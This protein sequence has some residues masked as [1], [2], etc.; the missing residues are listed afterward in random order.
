ML[1]AKQYTLL[2][3]KLKSEKNTK[4]F[5]CIWKY[6]LN[7]KSMQA[8]S[9]MRTLEELAVTEMLPALYFPSIME[10]SATELLDLD[11]SRRISTSS[12]AKTVKSE[13]GREFGH[14]LRHRCFV[15][16]ARS[17]SFLYHQVFVTLW[18]YLLLLF[19]YFYFYLSWLVYGLLN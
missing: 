8:N 12:D 4:F 19:Y 6:N 11:T 3:F 10:R 15:V 7:F 18:F 13:N 5:G 17:R 14:R 2:C 9:P 16:T 1:Y